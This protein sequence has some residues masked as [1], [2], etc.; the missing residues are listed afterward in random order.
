MFGWVRFSIS[1]VDDNTA[2]ES[3]D[4]TYSNDDKP[5]IDIDKVIEFTYKRELN[6]NYWQ[7]MSSI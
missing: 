6:N 4:D 2:N 1:V 7:E 5:T 3:V